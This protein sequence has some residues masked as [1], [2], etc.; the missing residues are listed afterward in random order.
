MDAIHKTAF[1]FQF[2]ANKYR[3]IEH[4]L[5]LPQ[6]LNRRQIHFYARSK[7]LKTKMLAV[8]TKKIVF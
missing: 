7:P 4:F 8:F 5:S 2:A 3:K 6:A 1:L